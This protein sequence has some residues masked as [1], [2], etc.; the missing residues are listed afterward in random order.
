MTN[1]PKTK[2]FITNKITLIIYNGQIVRIEFGVKC[3]LNPNWKGQMD[4]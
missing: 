3:Y 1:F 4:H 2:S